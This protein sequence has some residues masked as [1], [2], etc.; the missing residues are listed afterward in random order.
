[1]NKGNPFFRPHIP[2]KV[3]IKARFSQ[4]T[5]KIKMAFISN[6]GAYIGNAF[7]DGI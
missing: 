7:S 2:R 1:M 5:V 3:N 6:P 4:R